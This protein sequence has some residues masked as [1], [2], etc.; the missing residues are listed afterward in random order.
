VAAVVFAARSL[1]A[2]AGSTADGDTQTKGSWKAI[3]TYMEDKVKMLAD[4]PCKMTVRISYDKA[5]WMKM[6]SW[7]EQNPYG[8]CSSALDAIDH[9]CRRDDK[10][11]ATARSKIKSVN[12]KYAKVGA[13]VKG[14]TLNVSTDG[15][16]DITET[17]EHAIGL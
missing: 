17:V 13:S 3:D 2:L 12:C 10:H 7:S 1:T 9:Y 14:G 5:S 6:K 15:S 16:T 4:E 11:A 8:L